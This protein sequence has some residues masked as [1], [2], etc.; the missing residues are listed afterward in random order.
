MKSKSIIFACI[1][2]F[3]PFLA[4]AQQG[5]TITGTVFD[6]AGDPLPGANVLIQ[7][8]RMGAATDLEGAFS[9]NIPPVMARGQ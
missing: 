6:K 4:F 3:L 9:I 5:A 2:L 1:F 7:G 8:T